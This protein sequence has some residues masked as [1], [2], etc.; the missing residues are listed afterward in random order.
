M[1]KLKRS[2]AVCLISYLIVPVF[3][4]VLYLTMTMNYEDI[5]QREA[6]LDD[7]VGTVIYRIYHWLPRTG[8]IYQRLAVH[9][10]T[11]Q[12]SFGLDLVFRIAIAA[13]ASGL[14]YLL[15][16]FALGRRPRLAFRDTFI[17]LGLFICLILLGSGEIF[18]F[19]FSYAH[20]YVIAALLLVAFILP[21]RLQLSSRHPAALIGMLVLGILVGLSSEII[22]VALL[23][24]FAGFM[25]WQFVTHR[26]LIT[27]P[28]ELWRHYSL[29][30]IGVVGIVCGIII[31]YLGA[32]LESRVGGGYGALY[33]YISPF[34]VFTEPVSTIRGLLG[35][36]FYNIRHLHFAIILMAF[37]I[38]LEYA[39]YRKRQKQ[40]LALQ[41]GCFAFCALYV[42]ATSLL[43]VH[44]DLYVRLM[45]PVF[46]TVYASV[47]L[48]A[49][50]MLLSRS[51][52][53]ERALRN[54]QLIAAAIGMLMV[55][56]LSYAMIRYNIKA[57]PYLQDISVDAEFLPIFD[58]ALVKG[59]QDMPPSPIFQFQQSSPFHWLNSSD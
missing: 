41:V 30:I 12:L 43:A 34:G 11:P 48:Y 46:I 27:T 33:D 53:T 31:Y 26:C 44:D 24:I 42:S 50:R 54:F 28:Y 13:M 20:N 29:Q 59:E 36:L 22:P 35:H 17:F 4:L 2:Q 21:Y 1:R 8:E 25:I 47:W 14:V 7:S 3:F 40:N 32:S 52:F 58:A 56:D 38:L 45:A 23:M 49:S 51:I 10:M 15:T 5:Y 57:R 16:V 19:N 6:Y 39:N 55:V 18:T 9:L 37:I